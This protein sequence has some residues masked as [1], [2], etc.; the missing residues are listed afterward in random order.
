VAYQWLYAGI[1]SRN[2]AFAL[3]LLNH[4]GGALSVYRHCEKKDKDGAC[5]KIISI[6]WAV[7]GGKIKWKSVKN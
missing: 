6:F 5:S 4:G 3:P 7:L 1:M 2:P